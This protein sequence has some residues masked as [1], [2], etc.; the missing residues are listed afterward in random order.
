MTAIEIARRMAELNRV[1]D[2]QKAY[3]LAIHENNGK[4]PAV[5]MEASLYL[6]QSGADYRLPFTCFRRLYNAGEFQ[7]DC[8]SILTEAFYHPNEEQLRE[9]YRRNC[10]LLAQYP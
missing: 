2:A 4:D 9:A 8:F 1:E 6:L 3:Q 7:E 10:G 5:E